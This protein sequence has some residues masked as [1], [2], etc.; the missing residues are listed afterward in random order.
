MR[1]SISKTW[2]VLAVAGALGC[3]ADEP[4]RS[5]AETTRTLLAQPRPED[6]STPIDSTRLAAGE[7]QLTVDMLGVNMG[8]IDAPLK[9]IEFADFGCGF[10]RRFQAESFPAIRAEFIETDMIEWKFMPFV[11]GM[12]ANSEVV[13]EAAEC[14]LAQGGRAFEAFT[15]VL[16]ARQSDWRGSQD[17]EGLVRAWSTEIGLDTDALVECMESDARV[18]RITSATALAAELGVRST[19]TFWIVGVGPVQGALPLDT[20]RELFTQMHDAI[21]QGE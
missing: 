18:N 21:T 16:W 10:C 9:V 20:F 17:P 12:F 8:S 3:G 19:P 7:V 13:T 5:S 14:A 4:E 6:L 15:A 11:S 1:G 2:L